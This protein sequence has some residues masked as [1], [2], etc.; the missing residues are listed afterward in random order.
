MRNRFHRL[1]LALL[2]ALALA[3]PARADVS[4]VDVPGVCPGPQAVALRL[5]IDFTPTGPGTATVRFTVENTSGV[6][7]FQSPAIGNPVLTGFFFNIPGGASA[8]YTEGRLLAGGT[9]V[10]SGGSINGIPVPAGCTT[11]LTDVAQTGWYELVVGASTG[12]FGI[13][14]TGVSTVEGIKGG[15]VDPDVVIACAP[16]GDVFSPIYFAG[17]ARF[18]VQLTGLPA[19]FDSAQDFLALCST[20][21]GEQSPSSVA[22]KMQGTGQNGE[23]SC[24]AGKPCGPT[25][26][27]G[28]TWGFVKSMYR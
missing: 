9:L 20:V 2:A 15:L 11:L 14:T 25:P 16:Q 1:S 18:T 26:T 27:R 6:Y 19:S 5:T 7:P 13:F 23:G 24:F 10:S 21:H 22:G 28:T 4:T 3:A 12:Q 17:R 8:S